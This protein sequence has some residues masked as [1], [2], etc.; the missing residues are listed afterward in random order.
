MKTSVKFAPTTAMRNIAATDRR[1]ALLL[2][3]FTLGWYTRTLPPGLLMGDPGE[4]QFAAWR[5]GLAHPTGYPFYLILGGIWQRVLALFGMDPAFALNIFSTVTGALTVGLLYLLMARWLPSTGWGRLSALF[6]A[7]LFAFSPTFWS[8]SI[9]A[10]VY[11]LHALLI[12]AVLLALQTADGRPQHPI[13]NIHSPFPSP[14]S[15]IT[16]HHSPVPS[17][18]SPFIITLLLGLALSHHRTGLF[19]LPGVILW[20]FWMERSWWRNMRIWIIGLLGIG[21]P[22]LLY[23][24]IP[25][26]SVPDASPWLYPRL[27]GEVLSLYTPGWQGFI[28]HITGSVFA[29]SLLGIDGALARLPQMVEFWTIHFNA[30]GLAL[31]LIGLI[32]LVRARR[33]PI[34]LLTVPFALIHQI[35]N[36]FYGIGDIFVFYIPLYLMG[37]IWAGFG[38]WQIG[39]I[40]ERPQIAD[41]PIPN[42]QSP[43]PNPQSPTPSPQ[44][45]TPNP[46]YLLQF[47][48]FAA[49]LFFTILPL[50]RFFGEIDQ[51]GNNMARTMWNAILAADPPEDAVLV[52]NDRNEIVPLYYLQAVEGLAPGITGI[53]PLL[54]PEDRFGDVG[55]VIETAL[56]AGERPV[57]LIKPMDALSVRFNLEASMPPLVRV[58]S[59]VDAANVEHPLGLIF[60]PLTLL[61]YDRQIADGEIAL[62]WRVDAPLDGDYTT[63]VQIFDATGNR[64]DQSDQPPGHPFYPTSLWKVGD[65]LRE[66]HQVSLNN[67]AP[68]R[69]LVAMYRRSPG[70]DTE[71][72][73]LA[74][75]LEIELEIGD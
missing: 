61:G 59:I 45:P 75:S 52:S 68:A 46:Q 15:L 1:L 20:L 10:E 3:A 33:W 65:I 14:Q 42:P 53:F 69:L 39:R 55:S 6:A 51:S 31:V 13:P 22:Q 2:I 44:S 57:Y 11:T 47:A 16:I 29:V 8:Q 21:L 37:A 34:L 7:L 28:E 12:V 5:F 19:L 48:L 56:A 74:P 49:I 25:L 30:T 27:N 72:I 67:A 73:Y 60:G 40:V 70:A 54:T 23:L 63:T 35:F 18:Q 43:V 36:L 71:L 62:Y 32:A 26:R 4:F 24:Y 17:P 64:I 58:E 9:I 41:E 38:V 66:R 50:T